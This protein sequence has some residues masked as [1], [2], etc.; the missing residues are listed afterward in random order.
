MRWGEGVMVYS[1]PPYGKPV[2]GASVRLARPGGHPIRNP[3]WRR[4]TVTNSAGA[5][6]MR[7]VHKARYRVVASRSGLGR[8]HAQVSARSGGTHHVSIR[9]AAAAKS[10]VSHKSSKPKV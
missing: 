10:K 1:A 7:A 3:R 9:L 8:G 5:F 4:T 2:A 6:T